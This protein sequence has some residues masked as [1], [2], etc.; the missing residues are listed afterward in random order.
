MAVS[1]T[2]AT[3]ATLPNNP[4]KEVS[5]DAWN[6]G[7]AVT[8]L[9]DAAELD[10]GTSAGTVAA[11][12][13][14]HSGLAPTGGTTGQVL[15]K[16][17][18]TNYDYGWADD[19]TSE[20]GD[21]A[22]LVPVGGIIM[23]S[24]TIATIPEDWALCDG[25]ANAPGPDLRD[26]FIVGATSDDSGVAKTNLTGSLTTSGGAITHHHADHAL[27]QPAV[28]AHSI[29]QPA[30]SDHGVTQPA[31]NNHSI[32]Q[33]VIN[34]HSVTQPVVAAHSVTQPV[35]NNHTITQPV[36]GD[37]TVTTAGRRTSTAATLLAV[38]AVSSH[39]LTTQV[40][41]SAHTL[42]T[43][44]GVSTHSLD[45]NVAV[46]AHSLSTNVALD[47]HSLSTNVAVS[48]H[49]ISQNVAVSAHT[50]SQNAAI[51]AHDTLSAPQPYYALA[52]IQRMA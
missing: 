19:E 51:D 18:N 44:V 36:V 1:V 49:S 42:S 32:T 34:N 12:D 17:S 28:S 9:G 52:F 47:A 16:N 11:G 2:H 8:G 10:V 13:H 5:S 46:S 7:H 25:T 4:E 21:P 37:H 23:W 33:P 26:K 22:G 50:L 27:T 15:K 40:A 35:V 6:E 38:T 3:Q 20:G 30:Y 24:G 14:T 29:T 41:V 31:V 43:N 48:A 45:T 39:A